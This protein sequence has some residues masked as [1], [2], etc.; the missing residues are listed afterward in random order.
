[1]DPSILASSFPP[2]N[3]FSS[4]WTSLLKL[5]YLDPYIGPIYLGP[6]ICTYLFW[7][8]I[9]EPVYLDYS[10]FSIL[11]LPVNFNPSNLT[12]LYEHVYFDLSGVVSLC[13]I[14]GHH[15]KHKQRTLK[16]NP[17]GD[18]I[19]SEGITLTPN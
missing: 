7:T 8:H 3:F 9:F 14:K 17:V 15:S 10:V 6:S 2:V 13:G 1:M 4:I 18:F 12:R 5:V 11:F 16:L 19:G